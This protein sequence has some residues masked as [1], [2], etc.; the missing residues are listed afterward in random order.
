[1]ARKNRE[2]HNKQQREQKANRNKKGLC[3]HCLNE[4]IKNSTMC[5]KHW[6][7]DISARHFKTTKYGEFLKTQ[8]TDKNINALT[9]MRF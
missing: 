3:R 4:R 5:E 8:Q 1:M 6:Y 2:H 7:E 9:L